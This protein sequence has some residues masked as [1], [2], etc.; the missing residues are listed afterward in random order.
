[1]ITLLRRFLVLAGLMFWQGGFTF[2][3]G[4][5]VPVG[6][7]V[8]GHRQ[9][10]FI[11][12]QVTDYLNLSGAAA[13]VFFAWDAAVSTDRCV[14]RRRGIWAAWLG[15]AVSLALLFWLHERMDERLDPRSLRVLDRPLFQVEHRWY[16]WLSTFQWA[17]AVAYAVL[18]IRAWQ[19]EERT[20]N[21]AAGEMKCPVVNSSGVAQSPKSSADGT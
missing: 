13:L 12:R 17:C 11:T 4:A 18:T 7:T 16:L 10:G 3:A 9:Q 21:L 1:M 8:V 14:R 15:M 20:K 19:G 2:Y 5:V 6:Q